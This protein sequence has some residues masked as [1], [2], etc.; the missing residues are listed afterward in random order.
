M[1]SAKSA[2][3]TLARRPSSP[4]PVGQAFFRLATVVLLV[5]VFSM[6]QELLVP[7]ALSIVLAFALTPP[8]KWLERFVGRGV[9]IALVVMVA[10]GALGAFGYLLKRQMGELADQ[11][12]RYSDSM[13]KKV[14]RLRGNPTEGLSGLSKTVDKVIADLDD[15]VTEDR[16][17]RPVKLVPVQATAVER[18]TGSLGP[19]LE[20]LAKVV[21][22]LVLVLFLLGQREE[23]R[24]RFI[25]LLGRGNVTLT[26]R[27]LDEA[28]DRISRFLMLQSAI[29]GAFGIVVMLGLFWIGIPYAP[30]WG[31]VAAGLRFIPFVGSLLA[32]LLPAMLAF[33]QYEGWW[34]TGATLGLFIALDLIAAY[35]VEPLVIGHRT[36]VSSMAMVVAAIF[37]TWL[38]GPVGLVLSTPLTVCLAVI[39]KHVPRLEAL[40]VLLGDDPPLAAELTFY[41]RLLAGD[42]D[43]A[44][45]I[46][47][48]RLRVGSREQVF[49]EVLIP[50]LVRAERDRAREEIAE[51]DLDYFVQSTRAHVDRLIDRPTT[52]DRDRASVAEGQKPRHR[53]LGV[54]SRNDADELVWA[55]LTHLFDTDRFELQSVGSDALASEVG[56]AAIEAHPDII[57]VTCVPPGGLTHAR[58]ICKRLRVAIPNVRILVIRP[59]GQVGEFAETQP[60]T[61]DATMAVV[62]TLSEA[63]VR[64]DQ[65]LLVSDAAVPSTPT[66]RDEP[67][68][69]AKD[70]A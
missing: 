20:P 11:M 4:K 33:A 27:T 7:I 70:H 29:N 13:R 44:G 25:R 26:T 50:A 51:S 47:E 63:R 42:D 60:L 21:I 23:L 8:V 45:D 6:A 35:L 31:F 10:L 41:Q 30:L 57:C 2:D 49:D 38:W 56:P 19:V 5:A 43:E 36:G 15:K 62:A 24:N 69:V 32:M 66:G 37:W 48:K 64:I 22:V 52:K 67:G 46:L 3:R 16:E 40:A 61:E 55:M 65:M 68:S 28:G 54:P 58:H 14:T 34:Q 1:P 39:G 53:I 17:A 12:T 18:L 59:G 9:A